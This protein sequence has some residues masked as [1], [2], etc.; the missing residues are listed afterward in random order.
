MLFHLLKNHSNVGES[1]QRDV[2]KSVFYLVRLKVSTYK[3]VGIKLAS[4]ILGWEGVIRDKI[5]DELFKIMS[6]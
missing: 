2:L 6:V 5:E 1:A 3:Q 4:I